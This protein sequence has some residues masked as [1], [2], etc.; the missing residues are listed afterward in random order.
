MQNAL[1]KLGYQFN[2]RQ[3]LS[4]Q[5]AYLNSQQEIPTLSNDPKHQDRFDKQTLQAQVNFQHHGQLK[6]DWSHQTSF[7]INQSQD[8]YQPKFDQTQGKPSDYDTS[9]QILQNYSER[10][11]QIGSLDTI[12]KFN[13]ALKNE[14]FDTQVPDNPMFPKTNVN[15]QYN[16]KQ[17]NL[18][19]EWLM[20]FP[21]E[22]GAFIPDIRF[23][24]L[25]DELKEQETGDST[26]SENDVT[27]NLG[28][29]FQPTGSE[30][31]QLKSNLGNNVRQP[32]F[33]EKYSNQGLVKGNPDLKKETGIHRDISLL[34]S[35]PQPTTW[36]NRVHFSVSG[37][38]NDSNDVIVQTY[39]AQGVGRAVNLAN[40]NIWGSELE[41]GLETPYGQSLQFNMTYQQSEVKSSDVALDQ[42]RLPNQPEWMANVLLSQQWQGWKLTYQFHFEQGAYYDHTN[43]LPVPTQR[44]HDL[45]LAY[46]F[47]SLRIRLDAKNLQDQQLEIFNGFPS[48]GRSFYLTLDTHF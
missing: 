4:G 26:L 16:R 32:S 18:G 34:I 28:L 15:N 21:D 36:L 37:F 39:N 25:K 30:N 43:L 2:S 42:T 44:I 27:G 1:F 24:H 8:T 47:K 35:L 46:Q 12:A 40:A 31:L 11:V 41:S 29:V 7:L 14:Q 9:S 17:L 6:T 19:G 13:V 3:S 20:H 38:Y 23:Q 5:I 33:S 22:M 48:P 45:S 10:F